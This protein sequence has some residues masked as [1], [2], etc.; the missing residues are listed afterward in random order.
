MLNTPRLE[1]VVCIFFI[2]ANWMIDESA[3]TAIRANFRFAAKV[4]SG[5]II[6]ADENSLN[7]WEQT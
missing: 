2:F 5:G 4:I 7:N 1:S 6:R 3:P